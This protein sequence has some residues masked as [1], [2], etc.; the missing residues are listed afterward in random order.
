MQPPKPTRVLSILIAAVLLGAGAAHAQV[1]AT[2]LASPTTS[3]W[4][5]D[6]NWDTGVFPNGPLDTATFGVSNTTAITVLES[7]GLGTEVASLSFAAGASSYTLT[8]VEDGVFRLSGQGVTNNS[9]VA[10]QFVVGDGVNVANIE[11]R[12]S[13]SAGSQVTYETTGGT[14]WVSEDLSAS[15]KIPAP[16]ARLL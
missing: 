1:N 4:R 14:G 6:F 12:N 9:G 7:A 11:F 5:K 10:Q 2:W 8:V 13:A 3:D 16:T 15:K